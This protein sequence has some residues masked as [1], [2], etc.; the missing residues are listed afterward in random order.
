MV[1]DEVHVIIAADQ[2]MLPAR[3]HGRAL[4][5]KLGFSATDATLIATAI[6][7]IAR[8]IVVHVGRGEI[9]DEAGARRSP[10]R[11][12]RGRDR[13]G[14]RA[15]RISRQRSRTAMRLE[16]AWGWVCREPAA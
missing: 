15:S 10:V 16:A 1:D 5:L 14:S 2:D 7:E 12:R 8:N 6:S 13:R 9:T 4:A 3:A 11:P